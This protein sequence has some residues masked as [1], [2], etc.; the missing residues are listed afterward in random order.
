M[1]VKRPEL[2]PRLGETFC[3]LRDRC[4]LVRKIVLLLKQGGSPVKRI[5]SVSHDTS[6]VDFLQAAEQSE[7]SGLTYSVLSEKAVDP[8]F[9]QIFCD[10]FQYLIFSVAE[11]EVF[12][13]DHIFECI[14]LLVHRKDTN[15][16]YISKLFFIFFEIFYATARE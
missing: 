12:D 5:L 16:F 11:S 10:A 7:Q 8:A 2:S 14:S 4:H 3:P 6:G 15:D 1:V 13:F 9:L